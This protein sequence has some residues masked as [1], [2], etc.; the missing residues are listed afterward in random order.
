MSEEKRLI[1]SIK[2]VLDV[3]AEEK[4]DLYEH[5]NKQIAVIRAIL[6][7]HDERLQTEKE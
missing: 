3:E 7:Y 5:Q 6:N 2:T 4:D 1:D